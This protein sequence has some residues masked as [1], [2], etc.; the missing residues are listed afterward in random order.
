VRVAR[1]EDAV[2]LRRADPNAPGIRRIRHGRGFRYVDAAGDPVPAE[3]VA[4][5]KELVIPPA[6]TD[7]WICPYPNAH[8]QATGVDDAG[9]RQYLYHPAYRRRQDADKHERVLALARR[10]PAVRAEVAR[11]LRGRGLTRR[12]VVAAALR[13]LDHGVF[14]TGGDE[15]AAHNG[16]QGVATLNRDDVQVRAGRLTFRFTA[17]GGQDRRC[18]LHDPEL[19][20]VVAAL[21]RSRPP[22]TE[23]LLTY[24][25][26]DGWREVRAAD[27]NARFKEL[28][29]DGYT[30]K[31]LRTWH[32]TVLAAAGLCVPAPAT[33]TA[34]GRLVR[35]VL[36]GVAD[37]L[38]NTPAVAR[39]SYVDP[40]IVDL[41]D[42]GELG[43]LAGLDA[44]RL[45]RGS[46]RDRGER[47]VI[48]LLSRAGT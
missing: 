15:Y 5:I 28:A 21:R 1:E 45:T 2:R 8:L 48:R 33:A 16:S 35:A 37:E 26:D 23:R 11:D 14:R 38:G 42:R 4:R 36:A 41:F 25:D 22:G 46:V 20:T 12:R 9:R 6:W 40:R 30:V 31:D 7:V 44:S 34:R 3:V 13:M 29:G 24:R 47:A 10:L 27:V 17:K 43:P 32:A 19:A 39:A 18:T